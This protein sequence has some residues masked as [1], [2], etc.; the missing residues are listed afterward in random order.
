MAG[1]NQNNSTKNINNL[2]SH[3]DDILKAEVGA[4]LFNLGKTCINIE[5]WRGY[6]ESSNADAPDIGRYRDYCPDHLGKELEK[7]SPE[8]KKF[9][10]DNTKV[11]LPN[12]EGAELKD[13]LCA[14][15]KNTKEFIEKILMRGCENINSGIDKGTPADKL[16]SLWISNAFGGFKSE[17]VADNF[18]KKRRDFFRLIDEFLRSKDFY[19][20]DKVNWSEIRKEIFEEIYSWY[21]SLLSDNRFP[22]NDVTLWDQAYMTASM[23]KAALAA[24]YI[25]K[26]KFKTYMENP[27]SVKWSILGVQ[28]DKLGLAEKGL[29]PASIEWYR[30]ASKEIDEEIKNKIEIEYA[31][32]NEIYRDETGVYFIVP[33]NIVNRG[34]KYGKFYRLD[35]N[36][37]TLKDDIIQLFSDKFKGEVYPAIL[38]TE[39]SRGL[40]NLGALVESAK[41]NFLSVEYP[42]DFSKDLHDDGCEGDK[43]E[44]YGVCQVCGMRLACKGDDKDNLIC[45]ICNERQSG[46]IKKWEE[47]RWDNTIWTGELKDDNNRIALVSLK[48]DLT[49]WLN[50]DLMNT[51]LIRKEDFKEYKTNL[52]NFIYLFLSN[53][54]LR[55][56]YFN[57][58]INRLTREV[59]DLE[60]RLHAINTSEQQKHE[61]GIKKGKL[62]R[63][64]RDLKDIYENVNK[65]VELKWYNK[66][67]QDKL[68][69]KS[70]TNNFEGLFKNIIN[71]SKKIPDLYKPDIL[72]NISFFPEELASDAY[73]GCKARGES[74]NSFIRQIFF[75][76]IIGN[77]V[78]EF[79]KSSGLSSKIDWNEYTINWEKL[80]DDDIEFLSTILL[81]F[82]LR[83]NPSPA[84][85]RRVWETTQS[86]FEDLEKRILCVANMPKRERYYWKLDLKQAGKKDGEYED[87]DIEFWKRGNKVYMISWV[88]RCNNEKK[89]FRPRYKSGNPSADNN[90]LVL[91]KNDK[92]SVSYK[93]YFTILEP[94]PVSWQF[95]IPAQY[96]PAL[97][98]NV[99]NEYFKNFGFVYGKLP[100]R[101]G[102]VIQ[103]YKKPLYIGIKALRSLRMDDI[104]WDAM[105]RKVKVYDLKRRN[106]ENCTDCPQGN[107]DEYYSLY[108]V[109]SNEKGLYN[110]YVYS[111][112]G[113]RTI[114]ISPLRKLDHEDTVYFYPNTFDFEFLDTNARRND[115]YYDKASAQRAKNLKS[116]RP[117]DLYDFRYFED[118]KSFFLDDTTSLN[119]SSSQLQK[120]IS[121][122]YSKLEDWRDENESLKE[123]LISAF[124]NVLGLNNDD[125]KNKF[126]HLMGFRSFAELKG[127]DAGKFKK[128][129]YMLIDAFEFWHTAL[130]K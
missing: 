128:G 86:F 42:G 25:D 41:N 34:S 94:T 81:Q 101:V 19:K 11:T 92:K 99:E 79:I 26:G 22:V 113:D 6:F 46:R 105:K 100:L 39:P 18:D 70:Y 4:L 69:T 108:E 13:F 8:L 23:F 89:E 93:P 126:A 130:K 57:S 120:V 24:S 109:I 84:R 68:K 9:I 77:E 27:T 111:D 5:N 17:V 2:K 53:S 83:K 30:N 60:N 14:A 116:N 102:V 95:A 75:G 65:A 29:K 7:I 56:R 49:K 74:F 66:N 58:V 80:D 32:G 104:S 85:L 103:H 1:T 125:R 16:C 78:E 121:L 15:S 115:I 124:V 122:V 114:P 112:K 20:P 107:C 76:S 63:F 62:T 91:N 90:S 59:K 61:I 48:F 33:E 97:L 52:K 38:L 67:L 72:R 119:K 21:P 50:G 45:N 3:R 129:L 96:V 73:N 64:I 127:S 54:S 88:G 117:Y 87:G 47:E 106:S 123:F 44:V 37:K 36:F 43:K 28:Y 31:L 82:L 51:L 110:F 98:K 10:F 12:N 55:D 118:F 40:M 71:G 35:A